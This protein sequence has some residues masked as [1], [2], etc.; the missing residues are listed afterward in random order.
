MATGGV[1]MCIHFHTDSCTAPTLCLDELRKLI[2]GMTIWILDQ[3]LRIWND[4]LLWEIGHHFGSFSI[5][6]ASEPEWCV[7]LKMYQNTLRNIKRPT[8]KSGQPVHVRG[9]LTDNHVKACM[10]HSLLDITQAS[11]VLLRAENLCEICHFPTP[12]SRS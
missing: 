9:I 2:I 3:Y 6:G 4:I 5:L 12:R 11:R 1:V 8:I 7:F 10:R